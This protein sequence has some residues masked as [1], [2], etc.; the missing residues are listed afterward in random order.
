[1]RYCPEDQVLY[2]AHVLI[3]VHHHFGKAGGQGGGGR[4]GRAGFPV[5]QQGGGI[6]LQIGIVHLAPA[7]LFR[8]KAL[9]Q[10]QREIQ[11][12]RHGW[13]RGPQV[14]QRLRRG[15][16][17]GFLKRRARALAALPNG[18]EALFFLLVVK[19]AQRPQPRKGDIGKGRCPIPAV[20]QR[21]QEIPQRLRGG[22][23]GGK[24]G[25][26][27]RPARG[28]DLRERRLHILRALRRLCMH[29]RKQF[30]APDGVPQVFDPLGIQRGLLRLRPVRRP[31]LAAQLFVERQHRLLQPAVVPSR[32]HRIRQQAKGGVGVNGLI[33]SVQQVGQAAALELIAPLRVQHRKG[34]GEPQHMAVLPQH[35][36]AKAVDGADVGA[37]AQRLLPPQSPVLGVGG[38]KLRQRLRDAPPQLRRRRAGEGDDQKPVHVRRR[39][40]VGNAADQPLRQHPGLAAARRGGDQQRSAPVF[41]GEKLVGR[42]SQA[43]ASAPPSSS[44][45]QTAAALSFSSGR[46]RSVSS[47][48]WQA[49]A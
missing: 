15:L 19:A 29:R 22:G 31:G 49:P 44:A 38:G 21:P 2:G 37:C 28:V 26:F 8:R 5:S 14:T 3:L 18:L 48:Q 12:R 9:V 25:F 27:Q 30:P 36:R 42:I 16:G 10:L 20:P 39:G 47:F 41:H 13:G 43:H 1:M 11:Q 46:T 4:G 34:G 32:A 33:M 35:I 7:A 17:E 40:G 45:S 23:K 24:I 6:V